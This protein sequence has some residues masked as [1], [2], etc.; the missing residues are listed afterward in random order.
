MKFIDEKWKDNSVGIFIFHFYSNLFKSEGI[1]RFET[2]G[3]PRREDPENNPDEDDAPEG[4]EYG[5]GGNDGGQYIP[6]RI[7]YP[8]TQRDS[9]ESGDNT[10][11]ERLYKELHEDIG[12]GGSDGL[13]DTDF[14]GSLG[15]RY[16][17]D[18]HDSDPSDEK[19]NGRNSGE[20]HRHGTGNSRDGTEHLRHGADRKWCIISRCSLGIFEELII[21]VRAID[22]SLGR[23]I[24]LDIHTRIIMRSD[25]FIHHGR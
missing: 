14:S 11:D 13:A 23:V 1:N 16:E 25:D 6:D 2:C 5:V 4:E 24:N 21:D 3:F 12:L 17:H 22:I 19:G 7:D 8:E 20:E 18:I 10:D 15:H 9:D